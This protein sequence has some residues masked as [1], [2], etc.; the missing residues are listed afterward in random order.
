MHASHHQGLTRRSLLAAG[1]AALVSGHVHADDAIHLVVPFGP[2][3]VADTLA[4]ALSEDYAQQLR[5]PVIVDNRPGAGG[6]IGTAYVAKAPPDGRTLIFAA[7]SHT[8][9]PHLYAKVPYDPVRDFTPIAHV[10]NFGFVIAISSSVGVTSLSDFVQLV[11][12]RPGELNFASS[13]AGSAGHL[14]MAWFLSRA[15]AR[16]EHIPFNSTGAAVKEVMAGRAQ[17]IMAPVTGLVGFRDDSRI[18]LVAYSGKARSRTLPELPTIAETVL[19]GFN[20]EAWNA[21]LGPAHIPPNTVAHLSS[22][23]YQVLAQSAMRERL[24]QLGIE[25]LP[26]PVPEFEALLRQD[27][28]NA[29]AIVNASGARP[30]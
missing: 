1:A 24:G 21:V 14:G 23:L 26:L 27:W 10:G 5:V 20:F 19:P 4:R 12:T 9:A 17:A 6:T 29:G 30:Q 7:G 22:A 25:T 8:L 16:M 28:D 2:G 15:G 13:G 18:K 11:K 3:A